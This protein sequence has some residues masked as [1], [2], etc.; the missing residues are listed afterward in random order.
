VTLDPHRGR[1]E[2]A[3]ELL[4]QPRLAD[5]RLADEHHDLTMAGMGAREPLG[6][7][8]ELLLPSYEASSPRLR[9]AHDL[10]RGERC[11][12]FARE[13]HQLEASCE[14]PRGGGGGDDRPRRCTLED[15]L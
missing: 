4:H 2:L 11:S 8:P 3:P 13:W 12:R 7:Q 14:E 10:V 15:G 9:R 6:Q 5:P 1:A